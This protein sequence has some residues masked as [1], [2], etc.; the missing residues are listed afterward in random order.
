MATKT[1]S[2][3]VSSRKKAT[4]VRQPTKPPQEIEKEI[5]RV[6]VS[7]VKYQTW[8]NGARLKGEPFP[9]EYA[10]HVGLVE[11][12]AAVEDD[13]LE[14]FKRWAAHGLFDNSYRHKVPTET[15][16]KYVEELHGEGIL[17][18]NLRSL[19]EILVK[20]P[21][22]IRNPRPSING[23]VPYNGSP[24]VAADY[25]VGHATGIGG[26]RSMQK[27]IKLSLANA[28]KIFEP[29][30]MSLTVEEGESLTALAATLL[31][32]GKFVK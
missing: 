9:D 26:P 12:L 25:Y 5:L 24:K 6:M 3:K 18:G 1:R 27:D 32:Y 22:E 21:H 7:F 31:T 30:Q 14:G 17:K 8:Y 20:S 19:K 23:A 28:Q 10:F 13:M 15:L 16:D 2:T 4:Q 11:D 29:S